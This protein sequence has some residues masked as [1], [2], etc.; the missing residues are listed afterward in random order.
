[1]LDDFLAELRDQLG[2]A[3]VAHADDRAP[4]RFVPALGPFGLDQAPRL[5]PPRQEAGHQS[6]GRHGGTGQL[7]RRAGPRRLVPLSQVHRIDARSMRGPPPPRTFTGVAEVEG[8][9]WATDMVALL[10]DTW[11][12]VLDLKEAGATSLLAAS[13]PP[14]D[15]PTT[16]SSPPVMWP[17]RHRRRRGD[18]AGRRRPRPPTS[19]GASIS[20]PTT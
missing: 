19:S 3:D 14:S 16:P 6:H 18:G 9:G 8:Q 4:G 7:H 2:A 11:H 5:L 12:R 20:T 1:M 10:A 13:S 17:T 15:P